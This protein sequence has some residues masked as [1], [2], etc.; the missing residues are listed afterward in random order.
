MNERAD[1]SAPI[2]ATLASQAYERLRRDI[3]TAKLL[4]GHKLHIAQL[5]ESYGI[6]L[7]PVR[8]ALNRLSRDGLAHQTDQR[9]FR[10]APISVAHLEEL[11][12]TRCWLN[13]IGLRESIAH[14]DEAWEENVLLAYHRLSRLDQQAQD[15]TL[16]D[17]ACEEAHRKFHT[18]L[19]AGCRSQ[20]LLG[21]CEQLFDAAERYRFLSRD[22][23]PRK[24]PRNEHKAVMDA[25]VSR[26]ADTATRL[27]TAHL[28]KTAERV[29]VRLEA[30]QD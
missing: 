19:I 18:S 17:P 12:R 27:L 2:A 24:T 21:Y 30:H 20:W 23:T 28:R 9:G 22:S 14:G 13:E 25:A 5:C 7:S 1:F 15:S 29:R 6:G 16:R 11:T 10:V 3:I 4:P 8:E 26:D